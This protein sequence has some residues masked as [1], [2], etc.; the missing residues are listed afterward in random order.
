MVN[1]SVK[2]YCHKR[3]YYGLKPE[4]FEPG[5]RFC[6][7]YYTDIYGTLVNSI[8]DQKIVFRLGLKWVFGGLLCSLI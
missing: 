3:D 5:F 2:K 8:K 4:S 6:L 7:K 1:V